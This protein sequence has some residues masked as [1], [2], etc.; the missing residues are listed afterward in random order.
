MGFAPRMDCVATAMHYETLHISDT[1]VESHGDVSEI[2]NTG[3]KCKPVKRREKKE[4]V[5]IEQMIKISVEK[6]KLSQSVSLDAIHLFKDFSDRLQSLSKKVIHAAVVWKAVELSGTIL[7][8]KNICE[9]CDVTPPTARRAISIM[10][11]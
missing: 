6:Y 1:I 10:Q 3:K 5:T 4:P 11:D 8:A 2:K 9:I 7:S